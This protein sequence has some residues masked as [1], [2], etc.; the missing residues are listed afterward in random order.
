ME[1]TQIYAF[2]GKVGDLLPDLFR[3]MNRAFSAPVPEGK[4]CLDVID[5]AI[6]AQA[7][8]QAAVVAEARA[9]THED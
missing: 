3:T 9:A 4:S 2:N 8:A 1:R 7:D 6:K 5:D